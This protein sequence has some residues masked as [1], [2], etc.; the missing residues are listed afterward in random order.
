MSIIRILRMFP[1]VNAPK[2]QLKKTYQINPP[3]KKIQ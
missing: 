2:G 1:R 3:N